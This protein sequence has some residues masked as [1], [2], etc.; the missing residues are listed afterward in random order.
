T[1]RRGWEQT[2]RLSLPHRAGSILERRRRGMETSRGANNGRRAGVARGAPHREYFAST[3]FTFCV[4]GRTRAS[5][6]IRAVRAIGFQI[7]AMSA[8]CGGY[9]RR[10]AVEGRSRR[11]GNRGL[12]LPAQL[13]LER[14]AARAGDARGVA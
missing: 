4:I 5:A 9:S 14:S 12:V 8:R 13:G 6:E 11:G 3:R 7:G 1:V 2:H 10:G